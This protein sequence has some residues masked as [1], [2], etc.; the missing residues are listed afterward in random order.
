MARLDGERLRDTR[1]REG[2][3][4]WTKAVGH[5]AGYNLPRIWQ[6]D[7]YHGE[8]AHIVMEQITPDLLELIT[9]EDLLPTFYAEMLEV[10]ATQHTIEPPR[11][12]HTSNLLTSVQ[13]LRDNDYIGR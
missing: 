4:N 1:E 11:T 10:L 9:R 12:I 5:L 3:L 7:H 2:D 8:V 6:T 13:R